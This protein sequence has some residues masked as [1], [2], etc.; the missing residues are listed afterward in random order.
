LGQ[1]KYNPTAIAAKNGEL[2][3]KPKKMSKREADRLFY[4]KCQEILYRP[5]VDAYL[6]MQKEMELD[7]SCS[8]GERKDNG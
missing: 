8:Y 1:H 4:A 2:P 5:L 7:D 3:P 6:K